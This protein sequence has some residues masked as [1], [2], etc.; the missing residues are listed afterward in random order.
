MKLKSNLISRFKFWCFD[1]VKK[2]FIKMWVFDKG[3]VLEIHNM[4][5][6]SMGAVSFLNRFYVIDVSKS[7]KSKNHYNIFYNYGNNEAVEFKGSSVK[8]TNKDLS[9]LIDHH[10]IISLFDISNLGNIILMAL[11]GGILAAALYLI[12][13]TSGMGA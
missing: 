5:L 11:S 6:S 9:Q 3:R 7:I 13:I 8:Y 12:L 4:N 1:L 10:I 2:D